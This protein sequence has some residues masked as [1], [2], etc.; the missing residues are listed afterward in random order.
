M[1]VL[2][3]SRPGEPTQFIYLDPAVARSSRIGGDLV[4][5]GSGIPRKRDNAEASR[6]YREQQKA[7][8]K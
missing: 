2:R 7:E 3:L 5:G 1:S 4:R 6:R 8:G